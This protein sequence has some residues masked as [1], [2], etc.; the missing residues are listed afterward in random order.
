MKP[1]WLGL[2]DDNREYPCDGGERIAREIEERL[3]AVLGNERFEAMG[4]QPLGFTG[5]KGERSH[6]GAGRCPGCNCW[7]GQFHGEGCGG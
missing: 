4:T 5:A 2:P 6:Q 3:R 1:T 7:P